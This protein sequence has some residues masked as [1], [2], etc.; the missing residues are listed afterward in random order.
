MSAIPF[1]GNQR[2]S[3][4]VAAE[5]GL[6]NIAALVSSGE[7]NCVIDQY[8]N[9]TAIKSWKAQDVVLS[10]SGVTLAT[11]AGFRF[12]K[13]AKSVV[14]FLIRALPKSR[15]ASSPHDGV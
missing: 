13:Q 8:R 5:E 1:S 14:G 10:R 6:F 12:A 7:E 3:S 15:L 2:F 11:R 4:C 9:I